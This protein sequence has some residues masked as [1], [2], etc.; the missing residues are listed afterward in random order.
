MILWT[1]SDI[2]GKKTLQNLIFSEGIYY[3][4]K[5]DT[6]RTPKVNFIFELIQRQ[7]SN[8]DEME[9]RQ[10]ILV[11]TCRILRGER[12][13]NRTSFSYNQL[14]INDVGKIQQDQ[15]SDYLYMAFSCSSVTASCQ[16]KLSGKSR[17]LFK[18][19]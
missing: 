18:S 15:P 12:E 9:M 14:I 10:A 19:S 3:D 17:S 6:F 1:S 13:Y 8:T 4:R 2:H 7:I 5:N 16:L 11:I